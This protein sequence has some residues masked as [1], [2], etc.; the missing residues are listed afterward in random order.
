MRLKTRTT[1]RTEQYIISCNTC[2]CA[3]Y[4]LQASLILSIFASKNRPPSKIVTLKGARSNPQG[5]I[6]VIASTNRKES[7]PPNAVAAVNRPASLTAPREAAEPHTGA[8]ATYAL[9]QELLAFNKLT[10]VLNHVRL[11]QKIEDVSNS[12]PCAASFN[13][14]SRICSRARARLESTISVDCFATLV[15][16]PGLESGILTGIANA[17]HMLKALRSDRCSGG[18]GGSLAGPEPLSRATPPGSEPESGAWENGWARR[19]WL[20]MCG[21]GSRDAAKAMPAKHLREVSSW[22]FPAVQLGLR[23]LAFRGS[24]LKQG[25]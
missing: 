18:G 13:C 11:P 9:E 22:Q 15:I 14:R 20:A 17:I 6:G 5:S 7:A 21:G 12:S 10:H 8:S 3:S 2:K 25:I 1:P 19:C 24:H 23:L 16:P 4:S